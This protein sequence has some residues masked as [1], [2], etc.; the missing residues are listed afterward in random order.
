MSL[1]TLQRLKMTGCGIFDCTSASMI[2]PIPTMRRSSIS[3]DISICALPML[4][5]HECSLSRAYRVQ[6]H[7]AQNQMHASNL[8]IVFGP[9]LFRPPPGEEPLALQDMQWQCKAIETILRHYE[10][11]T[12]SSLFSFQAEMSQA[13]FVEAEE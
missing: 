12:T 10:V 6:R 4:L 11:R 2:C 1:T 8:A 9:T 5:H 3:W 7:G 13:I